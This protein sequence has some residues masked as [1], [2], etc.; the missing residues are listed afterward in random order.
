MRILEGLHA[1]GADQ[2]CPDIGG[3]GD[4]Q[5]Q[6]TAVRIQRQSRLGNLI[7]RLVVGEENLAAGGDPFDRAADPPGRPQYQHMLGVDEILGAEAAA[8]I[9]GDEPH[10]RRRHAERSRGMVAGVVDALARNIG[11]VTAII[12]IPDADNA[13]RFHRIGDDTVIVEAELDHMGR[14]GKGRVD[15]LPIAGEPVEA[16]ITRHFGRNLRRARRASGGGGRHRR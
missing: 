12:R 5:R 16:D 1:A 9:R 15:C 8:D 4:A 2:I 10:R 7:A 6:K 13:A 11:R 3:A 14:R